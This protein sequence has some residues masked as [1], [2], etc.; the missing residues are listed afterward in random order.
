MLA[1]FIF[2]RNPRAPILT[3]LLPFAQAWRQAYKQ[4]AEGETTAG[5]LAG[6]ASARCDI[7]GEIHMHEPDKSDAS[8]PRRGAGRTSST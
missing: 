6:V 7:T 8:V 3:H 1:I 2:N 5:A 4:C